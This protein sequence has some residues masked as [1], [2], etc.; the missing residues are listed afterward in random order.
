[1]RITAEG[2]AQRG[3]WKPAVHEKRPASPARPG[4][5]Q[6]GYYT[7]VGKA[8]GLPP[9]GGGQATN[10]PCATGGMDVG[11]VEE[12]VPDE[13]R[14][15]AG[16]GSGAVA[17]RKPGVDEFAVGDGG[18]P[19][20]GVWRDGETGV[21][22]ADSEAVV[23]AD[24]EDERRGSREEVASGEWRVTSGSGPNGKSRGERMLVGAAHKGER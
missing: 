18:I 2:T 22:A 12:D 19:A 20:G 16:R 5:T 11:L 23:A 21:G 6:D 9:E 4:Q 13:V 1:M 17:G 10:S 3:D 24:T 7:G 15:A 8:A 14:G